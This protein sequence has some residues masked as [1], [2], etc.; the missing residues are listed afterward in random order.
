M[1][2]LYGTASK[3]NLTGTPGDDTIY[4]YRQAEGGRADGGDG[5]DTIYGGGGKDTLIGGK[6][7]DSLNSQ[8]G[9]ITIEGG[10]GDDVL[11]GGG[12][13]AEDSRDT[14]TMHGGEGNN[15]IYA[16]GGDAIITAGSGNDYVLT[17]NGNNRF[18]TGLGLWEPPA[19]LNTVTA[20]L[21]VLCCAGVAYIALTAPVRPRVAQRRQLVRASWPWD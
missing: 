20:V 19:V 14:A 17:A 15:Q 3:N 10:D 9:A 18:D 11:F 13:R 8:G 16:G 6:G 2:I 1:A 4:L 5:N 7:N 12:G 21:F